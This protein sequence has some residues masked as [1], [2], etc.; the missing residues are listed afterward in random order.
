M[1]LNVVM[2]PLMVC[3]NLSQ[4]VDL[5]DYITTAVMFPELFYQC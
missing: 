5:N 3:F 1:M 2:M 4:C